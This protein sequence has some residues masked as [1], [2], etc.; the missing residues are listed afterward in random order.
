[1]LTYHEDLVYNNRTWV[2]RGSVNLRQYSPSKPIYIYIC[3]INFF[4]AYMVTFLEGATGI[5]TSIA[6]AR[7]RLGFSSHDSTGAGTKSGT[8][9]CVLYTV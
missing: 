7:L 8:V 4:F 6:Q 5:R 3:I 2:P 9:M 1:M